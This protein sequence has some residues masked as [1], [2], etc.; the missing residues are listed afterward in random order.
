MLGCLQ[1]HE[2]T[3]TK[4]RRNGQE[5]SGRIIFHALWRFANR[6]WI[7]TC[8]LGLSRMPRILFMSCTSPSACASEDTLHIHTHTY[9]SATFC[10]DDI[11]VFIRTVYHSSISILLMPNECTKRQP[12]IDLWQRTHW[13]WRTVIRTIHPR[14]R[15]RVGQVA[16]GKCPALALEGQKSHFPGGFVQGW[17]ARVLAT[18]CSHHSQAATAAMRT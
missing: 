14:A 11:W 18:G 4:E 15:L 13:F 12:E 17:R 7:C 1:L 10:D 3:L 2:L 16:K 6:I 9:I 5:R 8:L